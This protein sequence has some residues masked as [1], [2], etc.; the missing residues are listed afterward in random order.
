MDFFKPETDFKKLSGVEKAAAVLLVMGKDSAA[1][2][3]DFL[4]KEELKRVAG[5]AGKLP[6][7]N[8]QNINQLVE[9]FGENYVTHHNLLS[10]T[11]DLSKLLGDL[12]AKTPTAAKKAKKSIIKKADPKEL[13][14]KAI[15]DFLE[16][17][18]PIL[19]AILIGTLN[20]DLAA[21]ILTDLEPARRNDIFQALLDRKDL[22]PELENMF[23]TDL[24]EMIQDVNGEDENLVQVERAAGLINFFG[25]ETTDDIVSFIASS[26]PETAATIRRSLFK[27]SSVDQLS[28]EA[29]SILLDSV[30]SDDIVHAL[31]EADDGL[32]ESILD[33]LS[34][35]NRRMVESELARGPASKEKID[36]AQRKIAGLTLK[37][38]KDG[39]ISL[40][41]SD[42]GA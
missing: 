39:K 11:S 30:E 8:L 35:R 38:V 6:D 21:K 41:E 13:E 3:A 2:L 18:P 31:G 26:D 14:E 16:N 33:V 28:K 1:I 40:P 34:Q 29:R 37:L 15:Q 9:E 19:C 22:D 4:S 27:F 24:I 20:D 7:L 36:A 12:T 42:G 32:K 23:E 17:E 5:A 25:E 10:D